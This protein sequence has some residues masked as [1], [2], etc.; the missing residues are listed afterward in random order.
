[1]QAHRRDPTYRRGSGY[2]TEF[3]RLQPELRKTVV[4]TAHD[5]EEA[6]QLGDG[7]VVLGDGGILGQCEHRPCCWGRRPR[8][9][10]RT[11]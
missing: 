5:I 9:S 7:I 1:M 11:G 3:G 10:W 8:R 2:R 6:V 4:F